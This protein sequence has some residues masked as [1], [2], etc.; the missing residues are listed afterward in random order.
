[1]PLDPEQISAAEV[2][3]A[4]NYLHKQGSETFRRGDW[5]LALADMMSGD[6][7]KHAA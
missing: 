6:D 5:L 3:E 7:R 1:V 2:R 4:G